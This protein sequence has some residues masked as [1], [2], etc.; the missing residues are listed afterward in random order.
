MSLHLII[1]DKIVD[2]NLRKTDNYEAYKNMD[3]FIQLTVYSKYN[4]KVMTS[5]TD[6]SSYVSNKCVQINGWGL[7]NEFEI[8]R[9]FNPQAEGGISSRT[10]AFVNILNFNID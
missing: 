1:I 4:K 5:I 7:C 10:D 2:N 3:Q 6:I 8:R 9:I